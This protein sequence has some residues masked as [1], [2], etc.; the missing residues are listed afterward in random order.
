MGPMGQPAMITVELFGVPRLRAGLASVR[1]EA[2]DLGSALRTLAN[3]CPNLDGSIL[4]DGRAH[5]SYKV[6][7][8]GEAFVIDPST[9]LVDGDVLLL[10]AADVGG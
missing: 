3:A 5:P 1:V 2:S 6:S 9:A 7:L 10:L 4:V 8:N